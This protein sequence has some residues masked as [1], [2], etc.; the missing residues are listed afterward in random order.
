MELPFAPMA[1]Q[2]GNSSLLPLSL[3]LE[4]QF[5]LSPLSIPLLPLS[6]LLQPLLGL[7]S[8]SFE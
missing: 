4:D 8:Q 3:E 5:D 7:P 6:H 2:M 1:V